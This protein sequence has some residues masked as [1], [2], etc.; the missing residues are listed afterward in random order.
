[1]MSEI[2]THGPALAL[3]LGLLAG[4]AA[5]PAAPGYPPVPAPL[6]EQRVLPPVSPDPLIWQPGHWD[7]DGNSYGWQG[8]VWVPRAGHGTLW[9]DGYWTLTGGRYVWVPAHWM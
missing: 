1:M 5:N 3:I 9:Q 6:A 4:C 8:G 7:W 2:R